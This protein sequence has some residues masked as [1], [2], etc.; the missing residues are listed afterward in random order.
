MKVFIS[1][2]MKG[3]SD[4]EIL[5]KRNE[6][7]SKIKEKFGDDVEIINSIFDEYTENDALKYLGKSLI[8]M[9]DA[10]YAYFING[11]EYEKGCAFE[12]ICSK[13][14]G[15]RNNIDDERYQNDK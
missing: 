6:A 12:Y 2:P 8:L 11:C 13:N 4:E 1:Q 9:A 5:S 3:I 7:I 15:I 10:D 14:Y